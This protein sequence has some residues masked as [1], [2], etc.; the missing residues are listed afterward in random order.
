[1]ARGPKRSTRRPATKFPHLRKKMSK[2]TGRTTAGKKEVD[3][4]RHPNAPR[5]S[6][7]NVVADA[8]HGPRTGRHHGEENTGEGE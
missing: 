2:A 1:M 4:G 5:R 6:P 3:I 7:P 8:S